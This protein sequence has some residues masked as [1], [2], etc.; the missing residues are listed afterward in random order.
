MA[1]SPSRSLTPR[2][3]RFVAEYAVRR[4][5]AGAAVAAGYSAGSAKV[6]A[7][8]LL[9]VDNVR[10]AV[11]VRQDDM[12]ASFDL[13]KHKV[14]SNLLEA[15]AIARKNQDPKSMI[16]GWAEIA[17]LCGFIRPTCGLRRL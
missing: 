4:N 11:A 13:S 2:Q 9:T 6:T 8:R 17:K 5:G 3:E 1:I 7:S 14:I 15:V 12:A 16:D 10:R